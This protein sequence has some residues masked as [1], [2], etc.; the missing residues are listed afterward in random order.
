MSEKT[1]FP[2]HGQQSWRSFLKQI[3][4]TTSK[5]WF[6]HFS[7]LW[8]NNN[9]LKYNECDKNHLDKEAGK[10]TAVIKRTTR[11]QSRH[12]GFILRKL[13][14]VHLHIHL[15][16]WKVWGLCSPSHVHHGPKCLVSHTHTHTNTHSLWGACKITSTVQSPVGVRLQGLEYCKRT[17]T[18]DAKCGGSVQIPAPL[19]SS[20]FNNA[21][22]ISPV[23]SMSHAGEQ[24]PRW[25]CVIAQYCMLN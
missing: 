1:D 6:H 22:R 17:P 21:C 19:S 23:S 8:I 24:T 11:G 7:N 13:W 9:Q 10:I 3:C 4:V 14:V 16:V 5:S 2:N 20:Q 25:R 12:L 15:D 18:C